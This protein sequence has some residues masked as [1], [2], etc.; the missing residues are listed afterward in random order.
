MKRVLNAAVYAQSD[1]YWRVPY[2]GPQEKVMK[3]STQITHS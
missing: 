3:F 2:V 1:I